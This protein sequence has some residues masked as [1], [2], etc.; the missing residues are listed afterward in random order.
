MTLA[1]ATARGII[2]GRIGDLASCRNLMGGEGVTEWRMLFYGPHLAPGRIWNTVEYVKMGRGASC[3]EHTHGRAAGDEGTGDEGTEEIYAVLTGAAVMLINGR[4]VKVRAGDLITAPIG[5]THGIVGTSDEPM[6]FLV[7]EV[8][9][10]S[11]PKPTGVRLH[12]RE[13]MAPC[14][15]YRGTAGT[16]LAADVDLRS[17]FSGPWAHYSEIGIEPGTVFS[18]APAPGITEVVLAAAGQ[19]RLEADGTVM[20]GPRWYAAIPPGTPWSVRNAVSADEPVR[21]VTVAVSAHA[22]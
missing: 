20:T 14:D 7:T 6:T 22:V 16:V 15:G 4:A 5:T 3:G 10:R 17:L 8:Y 18:P 1:A 21:L 9:P 12:V 11:G 19:G 13:S 2:T